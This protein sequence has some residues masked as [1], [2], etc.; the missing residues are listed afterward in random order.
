MSIE[1][2]DSG[3]GWLGNPLPFVMIALLAVGTA[4]KT[5]P[6]LESARPNDPERL[7]ASP[8]GEQDITARLWQDPFAA[9][10]KRSETREAKEREKVH[11]VAAIV[12]SIRTRGRSQV[13]I[14]VLAVSVFGDSYSASAEWR[15]RVRV[16]VLSALNSQGYIPENPEA[17][18]YYEATLPRNEKHAGLL[19]PYEWFLKFEKSE[20]STSHVLVL[21]LNEEK[22]LPDPYDKLIGIFNEINPGGK[23]L[24]VRLIGPAGS[25][26]L[27]ELVSNSIM[28]STPAQTPLNIFSPTATI[29]TCD[30]YIKITHRHRKDFPWNCFKDTSFDLADLPAG[31]GKPS[32][33]RTTVTDD[34]LSAALLWELWQRGINHGHVWPKEKDRSN[35]DKGNSNGGPEA[36]KSLTCRDGVV[37]IHEWDTDYARWFAQSFTEGFTQFCGNDA[38]LDAPVRSFTYLRGVDGILPNLDKPEAKTADKL[39]DEEKSDDP[40]N[41]RKHLEDTSRE[42]AEGP[43]QYDYLVRLVRE[44]ERLDGDRNFAKNGV[45]AIGILG[46]DVYDKLLI[47]MALRSSF[48][49]KIFFTTDLD[50]RYLHADQQKW[51]RNLIVASSFGFALNPGLQK[52]I[53]PF[54]DTYQTAI[55]LASLMALEGD[56]KTANTDWKPRMNHLLHPMTFEIG[57]REAVHL[58]SPSIED[59]KNWINGRNLEGTITADEDRLPCSTQ[60]WKDCNQIQPPLRSGLVL[61]EPGKIFIMLISGIALAALASR[62][63]QRT[64]RT[65][66]GAHSPEQSAVRITLA[67]VIIAFLLISLALELIRRSINDSLKNGTGEPFIWLEGV[68]VWPSITLRAICLVLMAA[69]IF[70]FIFRLKR[71]ASRISNDFGFKAHGSL[72]LARNRWLMVLAGPNVDLW[73]YDKDGKHVRNLSPRDG[74]KME[75]ATLWQNYLRATSWREKTGWI[76]L[77]TATVYLFMKM[78]FVLFEPPAFPHRGELVD[79]LNGHLIRLNMIVLWVVIFW[80]SYEAR[81]CARLIDALDKSPRLYSWPPLP[82]NSPEARFIGRPEDLAGYLD[83]RLIIR[84]TQR[85]QWLIYLPFISILFMV[86]AR[87][88]LFDAMDFP[89]PLILVIVLSLSYAIHSEM[90]L[91][92]CAIGARKK[93][94][95][96]YED[97]LFALEGQGNSLAPAEAGGVTSLDD[98]EPIA[99]V[100]NAKTV[101]MPSGISTE[102]IQFLMED[103]RNTREGALAPLSHQPALQALLL[104]FGGYGGV[105]LIEYMMSFT[106]SS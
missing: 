88:D 90:L 40:K 34:V 78:L 75:V 76:V 61:E 35:Q 52:S 1:S 4:V 45:K 99:A 106:L 25:T 83:F 18:G 86:V 30:A 105:Q 96:E 49:D 15:R 94:L 41:L 2:K 95:K 48:K 51:T 97:R 100:S 73:A 46:S 72:K 13:P 20:E 7:K 102:Q 64:L 26:T 62:Y 60:N 104:P 44:I 59:L 98:I 23:L 82:A 29:S 16:S 33:I 93:A 50:A 80:A 91:R 58:A 77:S 42:H 9:I 19:V 70:A 63:M 37:L 68:S 43:N 11:S 103:I 92:K 56:G 8:M 87:S 53:P 10:E 74:K 101:S 28:S 84:A 69:L 79:D 27:V 47:L 89:L 39:S 6:S 32:I 65:A 3:G 31:P 81:A 38:R 55:Y 24:N 5:I 17:L 54:R 36:D 22:L 71:E 67:G 14:T 57:R 85:V 12:N 66:F 21:W